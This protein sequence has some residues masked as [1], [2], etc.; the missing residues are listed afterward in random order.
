MR[1]MFEANDE[2]STRPWRCGMIWRNA[3][4]TTRSDAREAGPLRVRRV[5]EQEVDAPVPELREPADVRAQAVDRRVVKLAVAR[6]EDPAGRRLEHDADR[7][8]DRM[9][10]PN[11][12]EP[13]R[14][15]LERL[16]VGS[17]SRSSVRA[18]SPCSSSFDFT[19]PSVSRV[20][21]TSRHPDLAQQ[22]RQRADVILVRRA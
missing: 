11:E 14:A 10:H 6:V 13:E 9:G 7:V 22:V 2:M 15:E 21:Q 20:A 17:I 18:R 4:P 19:S 1:W 5:A 12:L 3:S 8:R 16:A